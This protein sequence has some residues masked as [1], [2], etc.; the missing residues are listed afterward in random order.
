MA[1]AIGRRPTLCCCSRRFADRPYQFDFFQA[2]AAVGAHHRDKPRLGTSV[3]PAED[4]VRL[5]QEPSL[6]WRRRHWHLTNRCARLAGSLERLLRRAVRSQRPAAVALDGVRPRPHSPRRRSDVRAVS[7]RLSPSH[8]LAVLST[9]LGC[10]LSRPR[11]KIVPRAIVSP[12]TSARCSAWACRRSAI[13][14]ALPDNARLHFVDDSP[15]KRGIS[16]A[17]RRFYRATS[18][19]RCG[20]K[21]SW[22]IGC[23][24][25]TTAAPP[26]PWAT[27]RSVPR[28]CSAT[29]FGIVSRGFASRPGR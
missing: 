19:Y 7:G 11:A 8:A 21:S 22:V 20:W 4:F 28:S 29:T 9:R 24:C 12:N 1:G 26:L 13:A 25:R 27:P 14:T 16:T 6:A 15:A 17:C 23:D 2:A 3:R 18:K 5:G 10:G